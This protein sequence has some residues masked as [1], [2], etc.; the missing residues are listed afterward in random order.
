MYLD[1]SYICGWGDITKHEV[2][3]WWGNTG[4]DTQ[5][6]W[7]K[8]LFLKAGRVEMNERW[9]GSLFQIYEAT[10]ENDL[11]FAIVVFR[12][13]TE[14]DKEVEDRNDN[15]RVSAHTVE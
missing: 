4:E 3:G 14:I 15:D 11:D 6:R 1:L 10:D 9:H 2:S 8:S 13:G 12:V 7:Y 5:K